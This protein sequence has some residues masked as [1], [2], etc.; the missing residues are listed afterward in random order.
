MSFFSGGK[1]KEKDPFATKTQFYVEFLG[2]MECRGVRGHMY[3]E[4]VIQ[5]LKQRN[6]KP[7]RPPTL[8]IQVS[9]KDLRITQEVEDHKKK[10]I[11]K[12]KF[13]TIPARD[14]TY[15]YQAR[16]P[17]GRLDDIV[18]CIYLGY[19]PRTQKLVHVH[20][21]R[22]D[23]ANTANLFARQIGVL[24]EGNRQHIL[25]IENSLA[26]KGEIDEPSLITLDAI[27]EHHTTDSAVGSASSA[28]SDDEPP[29]FGSDEIDPDLQS[30]NDVIPFDN[31]ADELRFRFKLED[32]PLL[33]PPKDY[34]TISRAHGNLAKINQRRCLN[35][36]IVGPMAI[37][38]SLS[39]ESG[40]DSISPTSD[41]SSTKTDFKTSPKQQHKS[42]LP[43]HGVLTKQTSKESMQ[44]PLKKE[45][46][47]GS[48]HSGST[49]PGTPPKSGKDFVY[50][51]KVKSPPASPK[52][53]RQPVRQNSQ[54]TRPQPDPR[55]RD[56]PPAHYY[57]N[58]DSDDVYTR[59]NKLSRPPGDLLD[60]IPP[61]YNDDDVIDSHNGRFYQPVLTRSMPADVIRAEMGG[62]SRPNSGDS[63]PNRR[64][65][66]VPYPGDYPPANQNNY[67]P[68]NQNNY[69]PANQ[70]SYPPANQNNYPPA[71]QN[72]YQPRR[73]N[74]TKK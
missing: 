2:W 47:K 24:V 60:E 36:N 62:G 46:T 43:Q 67:P 56:D 15:V 63:R 70:N 44:I 22:F 25:D 6:R 61:D 68:A 26:M 66:S 65:G 21:Y 37:K 10:G 33:L 54:P 73:V 30:L 4:P 52:L 38:E 32:S 40:V 45:S 3:T 28:Y 49:S 72:S 71:N 59:H 8:T 39:K 23:E 35:M 9:K 13:P 7:E 12:I 48:Q 27:L 16:H 42:S 34:D 64:N 11:K 50:P 29:T 19:M 74:S 51:P 17:D 69:P 57:P 53:Y 31:V 58:N 55:Y 41:T 1:P 20:V 5:E 14:I 18:A